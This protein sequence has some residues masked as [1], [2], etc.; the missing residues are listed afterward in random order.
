ML[1]RCSCSCSPCGRPCLAASSSDGAV[2]GGAERGYEEQPEAGSSHNIT[3]PQM[4]LV[5]L[6]TWLAAVTKKTAEGLYRASLA[7]LF[8]NC[9]QI[10]SLKQLTGILYPLVFKQ[11]LSY[12]LS[13][14]FPVFHSQCINEGPSSF[15]LVLFAAQ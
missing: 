5:K 12:S 8:R 7:L 3:F 13:D 9:Y 1:R 14:S 15:L 6:N 4:C 2:H 10:S 11:L